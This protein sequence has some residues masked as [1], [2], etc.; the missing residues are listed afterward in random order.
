MGKKSKKTAVL[1]ISPSKNEE[2][3]SPP[4]NRTS[5]QSRKASDPTPPPKRKRLSSYDELED[6]VFDVKPKTS[7]TKADPIVIVSSKIKDSVVVAEKAPSKI[8]ASRKSAKTAAAAVETTSSNDGNEGENPL[9]PSSNPKAV[10]VQETLNLIKSSNVAMSPSTSKS[11][12]KQV[13]SF[14]MSQDMSMKMAKMQDELD[15]LRQTVSSKEQ[16][17]KKGKAVAFKGAEEIY[18]EW[19]KGSEDK[20]NEYEKLIAELRLQV[21]TLESKLSASASKITTLTTSR[22]SLTDRVTSLESTHESMLSEHTERVKAIEAE[23]AKRAVEI[24]VLKKKKIDDKYLGQLEKTVRLYE[25]GSGIVVQSVD[26]STEGL[27]TYKILH[28]GRHGRTLRYTLECPSSGCGVFVY[29]PTSPMEEIRD[30]PCY[31]KEEIEFPSLEAFF[32]R[33]CSWVW[34]Q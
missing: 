13:L 33:S 23:S 9:K 24:E 2:D 21:S 19:Q 11:S 26:N 3:V 27:L 32:E 31:L 15:T 7:A 22:Q 25:E 1:V 18:N 14:S 30:A 10:N 12:L 17:E 6:D 8:R 16:A 20:F 4:S 29:S 5:R 34:S 28:R